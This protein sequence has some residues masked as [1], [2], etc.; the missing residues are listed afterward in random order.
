MRAL[1]HLPCCF[2]MLQ[3]VRVVDV[4]VRLCLRTRMCV[5]VCVFVPACVF[6]CVY[7]CMRVRSF[8]V[9]TLCVIVGVCPRF[10]AI[11]GGPG[12]SWPARP[13]LRAR[14]VEAHVAC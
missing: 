5:H 7:A 3:W 1:H 11:A 4:C 14:S 9:V 10:Q 12:L 2:H 8:T 6:M 13:V